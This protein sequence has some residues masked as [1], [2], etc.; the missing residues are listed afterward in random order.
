MSKPRSQVWIYFEKKKNQTAM[1]KICGK[2]LQT[3]GNTSNLMG[4]IKKL[5]KLP[6]ETNLK[7]PNNQEKVSVFLITS[8]YTILFAVKIHDCVLCIFLIKLFISSNV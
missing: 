5:H 4:H 2:T 3:S 6:K 7:S 1:C 8:I